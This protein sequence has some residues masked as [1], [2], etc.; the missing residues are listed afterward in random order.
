M[1]SRGGALPLSPYPPMCSAHR[2]APG[3]PAMGGALEI[4]RVDA[5]RVFCHKKCL[6]NPKPQMNA[7]LNRQG[8]ANI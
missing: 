6:G 1:K 2:A 3:N 8:G 5:R 7:D 4:N